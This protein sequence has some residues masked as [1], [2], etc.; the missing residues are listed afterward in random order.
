MSKGTWTMKVIKTISNEEIVSLIKIN[1]E[2]EQTVYHLKTPMLITDD[3]DMYE[4]THIDEDEFDE[5]F[6]DSGMKRFMMNFSITLLPW[7]QFGENRD[8]EIAANS[9]AAVT[10]PNAQIKNMYS[11]VLKSIAN[12]DRLKKMEEMK[13]KSAISAVNDLLNGNLKKDDEYT[14]FRD[15]FDS[16]NLDGI[17][18]QED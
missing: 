8:V 17:N 18:I 1:P 13:E 10:E 6:E 14:E 7:F 15:W 12:L 16:L 5:D 4:D 2:E 11:N 9:I 3:M